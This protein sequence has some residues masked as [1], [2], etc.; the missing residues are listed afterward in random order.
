MAQDPADGLTYYLSVPVERKDALGAIRHWSN[1]KVALSHK[2]V[3]IKDLLPEQV[4][5]PA[6]KC[7]PFRKVYY[8]KGGK[9]YLQGS[10][11]PE[12]GLPEVLWSPIERGLPV[13]LP[14]FN[15]H[16]F[17]LEEKVDI[18]LVPSEGEQEGYALLCSLH[19]LSL[20][21]QGAPLVRLQGLCWVLLEGE[22]ALVIGQPLLPVPGKV[23]WHSE[24][25]L[26]PAGY[27]LALPGLAPIL[28]ALLDPGDDQW[29]IWKED[30]SYTQVARALLQP[31]SISSFRKSVIH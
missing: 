15:H 28:K 9:L 17:G 21:M 31:L 3:W 25:G 2:E 7:I 8:A 29:L 6:V 14:S 26:F 18:E 19:D 10:L 13:S 23:Y 22:R 16:F 4:D 20:F 24:G 1:L 11:L 30:G 12:R 5:A 27:D